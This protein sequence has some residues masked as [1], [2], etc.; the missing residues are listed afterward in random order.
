[1]VDNN[2]QEIFYQVDGAMDVL[3]L[4]HGEHKTIHIPQ[5][6][7]FILPSRIPHSPQRLSIPLLVAASSG[8]LHTI[9][10]ANTIG[11]VIE[12]LRK[13]HESDGLRYFVPGTTDVLYEEYFYCKDLG[14]ELVPVIQR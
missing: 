12:R 1:M 14:S 11:V 6:H 3:I 10:Y 7:M 4:E 13:P 8:H 5:G 2:S 9:R